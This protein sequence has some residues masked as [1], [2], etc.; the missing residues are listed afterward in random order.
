MG[1][2]APKGLLM[3]RRFPLGRILPDA[4]D[5]DQPPAKARDSK[6]AG[7]KGA[8]GGAKPDAS[9]T[10]SMLYRGAH[11]KRKASARPESEDPARAGC[12]RPVPGRTHQEQST[13]EGDTLPEG[14]SNARRGGHSRELQSGSATGPYLVD[15]NA[16][17]KTFAAGIR[18]LGKRRADRQPPDPA[19]R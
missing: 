8:K 11:F 5:L 3:N 1:G 18:A 14:R 9:R 17:R 10:W 4:K 7:P 6:S 15:E 2:D 16:A 13:R 12:Q 19:I